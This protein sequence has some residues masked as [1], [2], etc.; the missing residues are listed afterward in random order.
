MEYNRF[1]E[2]HLPGF[3]PE[4]DDIFTLDGE[5]VAHLRDPELARISHFRDLSAELDL[6]SNTY[7]LKVMQ[8]LKRLG[9][10]YNL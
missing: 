8:A 3:N 4:E 10:R 2:W 1:T 6:R 9:M 5:S 7:D